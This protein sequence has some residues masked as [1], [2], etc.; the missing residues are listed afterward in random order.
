MA[1]TII[2]YDDQN[3]ATEVFPGAENPEVDGQDIKWTNNILIGVQAPFIVV[4]GD[5]ALEPEA[6]ISEYITQDIK[7][8]LISKE[9]ARELEIA[10]LQTIVNEL[11]FGGGI[12]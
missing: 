10:Q 2:I 1:Y 7:E 3:K 4:E 6:D 8:Q 11:M 9:K 5:L 12:V